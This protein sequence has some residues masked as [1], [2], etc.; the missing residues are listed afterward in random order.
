M[1]YRGPRFGHRRPPFALVLATL[2]A[3][4]IG[5]FAVLGGGAIQF[6]SP[7]ATGSSPQRE[8]ETAQATVTQTVR[9]T[10]RVQARAQAPVTVI[11]QARG[12]RLLVVARRSGT[13]VAEA[14]VSEPL[15]VRR[16]ATVARSACATATT[17]QAA[18]GLALNIAYREALKAAH[19]QAAA[20]AR[21]DA[22][23]L[24]A[25]ARAGEVAQAHSLAVAR[26]D[27]AA[28]ADRARLTRELL[29]AARVEAVTG[30]PQPPLS[31]GG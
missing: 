21:V 23:A 19:A 5:A 24:V 26:A 3:V 25:R 13:V 29:Q 6:G 7:R 12:K 17:E 9:R 28:R 16:A 4:V 15:V 31:H 8:C 2:L 1:R 11:E 10:A 27:A 22:N 30:A 20:A 14:E 18:K